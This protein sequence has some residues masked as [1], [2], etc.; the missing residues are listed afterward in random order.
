M[1]IDTGALR[2][3]QEIWNP[4]IKAIPAVLDMAERQADLERGIQAK[5]QE[6]ER[7]QKEIVAAI[8]EADRRI[9]D[10]NASLD[11][12][13]EQKRALQRD[14]SEAKSKANIEAA[15]AEQTKK[16]MLDGL[17]ASIVAVQA[18]L[19]GLQAEY[20]A[21]RAKAEEDHVTAVKVFE[22]DITELN[23]RK[24]AAEVVLRDLKAKLG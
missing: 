23:A 14:I 18:Q 17:Q 12:V 13:A 24:S 19:Q 2:K 6:L 10:A 20:A 4:V 15:E 11:S 22:A 21:K 8:E 7:I 3:F 1:T 16:A 9:S 5:Q